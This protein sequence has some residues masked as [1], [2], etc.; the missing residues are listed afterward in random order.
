MDMACYPR[1]VVGPAASNRSSCKACKAKIDKGEIRVGTVTMGEYEM[2]AWRHLDCQKKPKGM[3]SVDGLI[4]Y[5]AL[6]ADSKAKVE[7]WFSSGGTPKKRTAAELQTDAELDPKKMKVGD[8]KKVLKEHGTDAS[9]SKK[10][11]QAQLLEVKDRAAAQSIYQ[12]KTIPGLK[13]ILDKNGQLKG[14]TKQELVERCVDGKLFGKLPRCPKCGGGVL[15][16]VYSSKVGHGGKG[17]FSCPG[18]FD[19]DHFVRCNYTATEAEREDW[20]D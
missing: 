2:T 17:K 9:G 12:T 8:M 6:D 13:E 20:N 16:V 19:D 4:G 11:M 14:G 1:F 10:E 18:Y 3:D 15:R 5:E 7:A